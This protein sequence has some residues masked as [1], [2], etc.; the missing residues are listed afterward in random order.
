MKLFFYGMGGEFCDLTAESLAR[1]DVEEEDEHA[2][3]KRKKLHRKGGGE[4]HGDLLLE[5]DAT[6]VEVHAGGM[7]A[8]AT[9]QQQRAEREVEKGLVLVEEHE[10]K[11][12]REVRID[13]R[14]SSGEGRTGS[15]S[16]FW[17]REMGCVRG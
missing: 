17:R 5:G 13:L 3:M 11:V 6:V 14:V 12:T 4:W 15:T 2:R 10:E 7:R 8:L 9:R 1:S 16:A